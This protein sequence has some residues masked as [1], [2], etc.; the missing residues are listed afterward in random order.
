MYRQ[1]THSSQ[2]LPAT[3]LDRGKRNFDLHPWPQRGE[4]YDVM[5]QATLAATN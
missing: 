5:L 2:C 3:A 1:A 4:R